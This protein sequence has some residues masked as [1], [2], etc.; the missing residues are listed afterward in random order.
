MNDFPNLKNPIHFIATL[1]AIGKL[2]FAPGTW[3]SLFACILFIFLSHFVSQ[4]E[5]LIIIT[6]FFSIWICE[7]ASSELIEKDHK[8]IVIDELAGMWLAVYPAIFYNTQD[9]RV[10]FAILAFCSFR[11]FDI[12]K[13]FPISYVDKN[14]KGGL[15]IVLDDLIAGVFAGLI[16][17]AAMSLLFA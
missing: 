3:G 13:P 5:I 15:G 11:V 14:V 9:E 16:S 1:G 6:I 7:K 10:T 8:S 12:F 17:I 4:I 2:P